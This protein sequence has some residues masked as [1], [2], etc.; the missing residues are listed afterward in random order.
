MSYLIGMLIGSMIGIWIVSAILGLF[1]FKNTEPTKRAAFIVGIAYAIAV[2]VYG[3]QDG[4][5]YG[6]A[7]IFY[8]IGAFVV[9][10][11]RQ[12]HYRK[13]WSD[14]SELTETFR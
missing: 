6:E 10:F 1:A 13:H 9:F 12:R 7:L 11:E 3:S 14:D 2:A 5:R 4:G 8:G